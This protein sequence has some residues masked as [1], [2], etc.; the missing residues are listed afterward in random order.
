MAAGPLAC[1]LYDNNFTTETELTIIQGEYMLVP[2]PCLLNVNL[3][4][5]DGKIKKLYAGGDAYVSDEIRIKI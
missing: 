5:E 1:Y 2:S 4:I 3:I